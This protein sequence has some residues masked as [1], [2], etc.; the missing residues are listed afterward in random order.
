MEI[1]RLTFATSSEG[2]IKEAQEILGIKIK[3]TSLEIEE[4]QSLD[5]IKVARAKALAYFEAL[6]TPLFVEDTSLEFDALNGLP[7]PYINDMLKALGNQGLCSLLK[8]GNRK[9]KAQVT[10]FYIDSKEKE[11]VF[12]GT[13]EGR[14]AKTPKGEGGFGWD[15]I[16]IPEGE[17]RTFGEMNLSEKNK[18]S[19]RKKAFDAFSSWLS[20]H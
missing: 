5:P 6:K 20:S 16:F 9:A 4:I 18:Y 11:H 15:P 2:K 1:D 8:E 19:M 14:L 17:T 3:G 13:C 12:V 7:G 10:I